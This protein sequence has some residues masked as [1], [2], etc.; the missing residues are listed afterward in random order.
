MFCP[1]HRV[2]KVKGVRARAFLGKVQEVMAFHVV[3]QVTPVNSVGFEL[4]KSLGKGCVI[5]F[6]KLHLQEALD[7]FVLDE[8]PEA[9][10]LVL[11][12][13]EDVV[14]QRT[15]FEVNVAEI[16]ESKRFFVGPEPAV[17]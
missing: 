16:D 5:R 11:D 3:W 9:H 7:F 14:N 13:V 6:D 2:E 17:V 1:V 12:V 4:L 8:D 15:R 10:Q